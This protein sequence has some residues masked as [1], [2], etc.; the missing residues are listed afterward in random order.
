[1]G[2]GH[3]EQEPPLPRARDELDPEHAA[4]VIVIRM[5]NASGDAMA[6]LLSRPFPRIARF[7][8]ATPASFVEAITPNGVLR[9]VM[10]VDDD[11]D[12]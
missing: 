2:G 7:V 6:D 11:E 4:R 1:M 12:A 10:A 5:K 3:K 9:Q 8:A